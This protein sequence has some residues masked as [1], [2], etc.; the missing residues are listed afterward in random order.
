MGLAYAAP[1][2]VNVRHVGPLR[3]CRARN[4]PAT[5]CDAFL[6]AGAAVILQVVLAAAN[7]VVLH[8]FPEA[9]PA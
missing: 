8:V 5:S 6:G 7:G 9:T 4:Y 3:W 1:R 2:T